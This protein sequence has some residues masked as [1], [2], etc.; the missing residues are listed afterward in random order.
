[1]DR[2]DAEEPQR[3]HELLVQ[4]LEHARD[5]SCAAERRARRRGRAA[6]QHGV[7]AE[8]DAR[9]VVGAAHP[10]VDQDRRL[11]AGLGGDLGQHVDGGRRAF[12]L[13]AAVVRDDDAV[14]AGVDGTTGVLGA[15]E[16]P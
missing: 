3:P 5:A 4:R 14:G 11:A 13:A 6:D 12:E 2:P 10:G 15:L 8:G 16:R 7:G 1:M 9:D